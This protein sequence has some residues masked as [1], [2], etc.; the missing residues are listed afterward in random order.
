MTSG[1]VGEQAEAELIAAVDAAAGNLTL[2]R[3]RALNAL[4]T[5]MR[6]QMAEAMKKWAA[7]PE[8]YAVVLAA[9]GGK[10]FCAGGDVRELLNWVRTDPAKARQSV[11]D[12][13]RLVWQIDC[14]PK[15]IVALI[16]GLVMGSGAGISMFATHR[17]AG[18]NYAFAMPETALGFF[19]D[20]GATVFLG[21]LPGAVGTY[22]GLTGERIGR[23]DAFRLGIAS[24]CIDREHYPSIMKGLA[25]AEVVDP[26]LDGFHADPGPGPLAT[27]RDAIDRCFSAADVPEILARLEAEKAE[28]R[29]WAQAALEKLRRASPLSLAVALRQLREGRALG[30]KAALEREHRMTVN[31]MASPDFAEGV[32]ALLVD[33]DGAPRWRHAI[34]GVAQSEVEGIFAPL[35]DGE[36]ALPARPQPPVFQE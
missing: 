8:I 27:R 26:L 2:N 7:D 31:H 28:H 14:F 32:R 22:L 11:A 4:N 21:R 9:S 1:P 6:A 36:L 20:V 34:D 17:V 10:A 30:L 25:A 23:A 33:K 15:P 18:P 16:D 29:D 24:H 13:Y 3:P 19:P 12:E 35:L 5:F